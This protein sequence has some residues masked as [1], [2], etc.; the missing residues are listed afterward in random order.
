MNVQNTYLQLDYLIFQSISYHM[1]LPL[2]PINNQNF[3]CSL[4]RFVY[5][6]QTGFFQF[7]VVRFQQK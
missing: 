6:G 7:Y 2:L 1:Y 4:T 5:R 3:Y